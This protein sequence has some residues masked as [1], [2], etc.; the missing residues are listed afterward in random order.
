MSLNRHYVITK[1]G[2]HLFCPACGE[3]LRPYRL[4]DPF[5]HGLRCCNGHR[6][7]EEI[8]SPT[9]DATARV[10]N[11]RVVGAGAGSAMGA[12]RLWL[13]DNKLRRKLNNQLA[14]VIRRI[15]EISNLGLHIDACVGFTFCPICA[16]RMRK[17]KQT[18]GWAMESKC[19]SGHKLMER[20]GY[21]YFKRGRV[22]ATLGEELSDELVLSLVD[23][24]LQDDANISS[25]LPAQLRGALRSY[26]R[27]FQSQ[28]PGSTLQS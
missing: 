16:Q 10:A 19:G 3:I 12:I 18:I 17:A 27:R 4:L 14:L 9:E 28:Q 1:R 23:G 5:L 13:R 24:W 2:G 26:Q 6:Y 21:L 8:K 15:Y 11:L 20:N 22:S 7:F 25:N